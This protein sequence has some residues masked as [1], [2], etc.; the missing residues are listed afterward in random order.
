MNKI[1]VEQE[2]LQ[3]QEEEV[4]IDIFP[5]CLNL[6]VKGNV[7]CGIKTF[8]NKELN[9]HLEKESHLTLEFL[10]QVENSQNKI[11][12]QN[13]EDSGIDLHY[14]CSYK[15]ENILD[16]YNTLNT[17]NNNNQI[18]VRAVENGGTL[19]VQALGQIEE[20]TKNNVY[21]EDI[22]A[23]TNENNRIKIK[24]DLVVKSDSIHATHNATIAPVEKSELFYLESKGLTK[25]KAES[26][27][28]EGFLKGIIEKENL[29]N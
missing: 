12:I 10:I 22:K 7:Y 1:I 21:L 17:S 9:I 27:I 5:D 16:I 26:L 13:E 24:P 14:A 20:E 2:E 4:I 19:I 6:S 23:I 11:T 25:E 29:K 28:K 3:L 15:G 8:T 18:F